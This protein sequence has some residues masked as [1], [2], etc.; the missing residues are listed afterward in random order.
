MMLIYIQIVTIVIC[1]EIFTKLIKMI[2]IIKYVVF[3][4]SF[5]RLDKWK[6]H[7]GVFF[8]FPSTF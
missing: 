2:E 7:I 6:N 8:L 1:Q 5:G 4:S 3:S